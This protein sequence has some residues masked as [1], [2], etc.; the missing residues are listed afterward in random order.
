MLKSNE[1]CC[2]TPYQRI[3]LAADKIDR[4]ESDVDVIKKV[5]TKH[6][7]ALQEIA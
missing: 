6:S 1:S 3:Q 2:L 4:M 7:K 5:V